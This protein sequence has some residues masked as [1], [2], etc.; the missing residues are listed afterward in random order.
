MRI[1]SRSSQDWNS[2][3]VEDDAPRRNGAEVAQAHVGCGRLQAKLWL[4]HTT[5]LL[6]ATGGYG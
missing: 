3:H 2:K 6:Y 4:N 1:S 5:T